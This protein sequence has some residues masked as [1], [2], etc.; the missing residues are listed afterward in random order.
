MAERR[1][2]IRTIKMFE[3]L[4]LTLIVRLSASQSQVYMSLDR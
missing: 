4:I 2:N 3:L 1:L